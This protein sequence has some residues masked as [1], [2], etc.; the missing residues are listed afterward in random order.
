ME[1]RGFREIGLK[2]LALVVFAGVTTAA[3]SCGL[4]VSNQ[5]RQ[6]AS[7]NGPTIQGLST[8]SGNVGSVVVVVG[9]GFGPRQDESGVAF[10]G[11]QASSIHWSSTK[12]TVSVPPAATTGDV[13]AIVRGV[14]SNPA[15]FT[16]IPKITSINP[17]IALPGAITT[18]RGTGFGTDRG[19]N[20]VRFNGLVASVSS[21]AA[22]EVIATVPSTALS[23]SVTISVNGVASNPIAF[24]LGGPII[25]AVS[26]SSGRVGLTVSVTGSS[27]GDSQ[28]SITFSGVPASVLFWSDTVI[29]AFVPQGAANGDVVVSVGDLPSN[30]VSFTVTGF[31]STGS[32]TTGRNGHRSV[33]LNDGTVLVVGGLSSLGGPSLGVEDTAEVYDPKTSQFTE[34]GSL[35]VARAGATI[36]LLDDGTVLLTGGVDASGNVLGSAEL[37]D[38]ATRIFTLTGRLVPPRSS[39]TAT[40]LP[41]GTVLVAGGDDG[42]GNCLSSAELYVPSARTFVSTG[43]L[44]IA[45]Y[46]ATATTLNDGTVLLA[47]GVNNG[48]PIPDAEVYDYSAQSFKTVGSLNTPRFRH[49]ATLLNTGM[50]LVV[51]GTQTL[52][53]PAVPLNTAELYDPITGNFVQT[54]NL[55]VGEADHAA[56][57]MTDGTV[58]VTGG[59]V[60]SPQNC[61]TNLVT[62]AS[63]WAV[64]YDPALGTFA[65]AITALNV[66]RQIH[67]ST[68]LP[69]G[70]VLVVGGWGY[71]SDLTVNRALASSEIYQPDPMALSPPN[72]VSIN[73][74]PIDPLV[75]AGTT[76]ALVATGMF[77][78]GTSQPLVSVIWHSA[79]LSITTV[80][81]D[82]GGNSGLG[83]DS[84]NAGVIFGRASGATTITACA[85]AIC[86]LTTVTVP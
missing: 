33:L 16:V 71:N 65:P 10:N 44:N 70:R 22:S 15:R 58:L 61:I 30:G 25:D 72:L 24:T 9:H 21:W 39:H 35:N 5:E 41:D 19:V 74:S 34:T 17:P 69:D 13:V 60:C 1:T 14:Q 66:S 26:P 59:F 20:T 50:V 23:G 52:T 40:R 11:V 7:D 8:N 56:T 12:I 4:P 18:I 57:L 62:P 29:N 42:S 81:N 64:L 76:Q 31:N 36:T 32:L 80:A 28:G 63:N 38:P 37:Y 51:G 86:G 68:L 84:T 77:S 6:S 75:P 83:N 3:T 53:N 79:D 49:T 2:A 67:T 27:F 54:G 78:D 45:R 46:D 47:G 85:G 43:S 73:I 82:S 48:N 55:F